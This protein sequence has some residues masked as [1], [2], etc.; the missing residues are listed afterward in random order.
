MNP[1]KVTAVIELECHVCSL[2]IHPGDEVVL[3][4]FGWVHPVCG[5]AS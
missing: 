5:A 1:S 3:D 2:N 4:D